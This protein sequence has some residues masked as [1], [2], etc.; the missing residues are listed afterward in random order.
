MSNLKL[1]LL[2]G[3]QE[4]NHLMMGGALKTS[5]P[6]LEPRTS[7]VDKTRF[8]E[9]MREGFQKLHPVHL[10]FLFVSNGSNIDKYDL[11]VHKLIDQIV[12]KLIKEKKYIVN[13]MLDLIPMHQSEKKEAADYFEQFSTPKEDYMTP[14]AY[15]EEYL[16]NLFNL[17]TALHFN[18]DIIK[19]VIKSN[20]IIRR[21]DYRRRIANK[22]KSSW[23]TWVDEGRINMDE[24][25]KLSGYLRKSLG[26]QRIFENIKD[27]VKSPLIPPLNPGKNDPDDTNILLRSISFMSKHLIDKKVIP[28][29]IEGK[30]I[31]IP[32]MQKEMG[33]DG[34]ISNYIMKTLLGI[35]ETSDNIQ[36]NISAEMVTEPF[37]NYNPDVQFEIITI[38]IKIYDNRLSISDSTP[39]TPST[40]SL[41]VF[42]AR[43][44]LFAFSYRDV[45]PLLT[46]PSSTSSCSSS[47][48]SSF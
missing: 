21:G 9:L 31:I 4:Y 17:Y 15:L 48:P 26:L 10:R 38:L 16:N 34:L 19:K 7:P 23:Q 36:D 8:Y 12:Q 11:L 20:V 29:Q 27:S 18:I 40:P 45:R 14:T 41:S 35:Y 46:S 43:K 22:D 6:T 28:F 39:S 1:F 30:Y 42:R 32:H 25:L 2:N 37:K 44:G 5:S 47:S 24:I 13:A 3:Y 33:L